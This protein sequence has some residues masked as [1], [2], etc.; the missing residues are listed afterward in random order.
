MSACLDERLSSGL[1]KKQI[2]KLIIGINRKKNDWCTAVKI[3]TR[4]F[5][6]FIN[7]TD[8]IFC[9]SSHEKAVPLLFDIPFR[10]FSSSSLLELNLKVQNFSTL[11]YLVD[12]RFTQ[13][14]TLIVD[15][16]NIVYASELVEKKVTLKRKEFRL[17]FFAFSR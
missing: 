4:I 9:E 7:L 3:C 17:L 11:L 5:S 12:G 2:K 16:N 1:F 10:R 13:L 15:L 6:V 8:L 14:H